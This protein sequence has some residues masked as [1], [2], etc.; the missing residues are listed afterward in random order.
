MANQ[1]NG[2]VA[3]ISLEDVKRRMDE[4][5]FVDARSS[6]ALSRNPLQVPGAIHVP[7]REVAKTLQ[8]LPR[9]RTLVTYCT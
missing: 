3:R 4:V 8:R 9:G 6:T 1:R 2:K 5:I 7:A